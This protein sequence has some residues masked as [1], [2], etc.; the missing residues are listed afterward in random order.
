MTPGDTIAAI[1]SATGAAARMILRLSGPRAHAIAQ[2]LAP[3]WTPTPASATHTR[4]SFANLTCPA[5]LYA[6]RSP[7]SYTGEDLIEFHIPGNSMLAK[8]LL[9]ELLSPNQGARL[10]DAGE[11]TARAY[12]AG[13]LD[14][15]EAEGVAATIAASNAQE[16]SAARQLLAG[17]L[18]HRL[19][20]A[21]DQ[22][23]GTL[24]LVEVGID[25]SEEDVTFLATDE[26]HRRVTEIDT[27]L[28]A[29]LSD[30]ARFERLIHEPRIVLVGRPNAGKSTLIN[31]LSGQRRSIVSDIA[32]T[33]RD[34]LSAPLDLQHGR[35]QLL[36]V[37]GIEAHSAPG[38]I[39]RQMQKHAAR[40]IETAEHVVLVHDATDAN[41]P[42]SLIRQPDLVVRS[43]S[44]LGAHHEFQAS[45]LLVSAKTGAG[46][47]S[48]RVALD[49]LTF[50]G[51]ENAI[52]AGLALNRRH[53]GGIDEARSALSRVAAACAAT[54]AAAE[55]IA[56]ELR[57]ALDA[58]GRIL[59]SVT[60][61]DVL[62]RIFSSFCIGK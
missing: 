1:S 61:D 34:V 46:L 20:P 54:N 17:E 30:S 58:L 29:L 32:G 26:I 44:D 53:V 10:A 49:H 15:S 5:W 42:P 14:L 41:P 13:K 2:S 16:L 59:G 7:H 18:A 31:A 9:D 47:D 22:L 51:S 56:L 45:Q 12:F 55:L 62:G 38:E 24:A 11:F 35:V 19:R 23:A 48:L 25:F 8:L 43:K 52:G 60:P 39:D 21:V 37:A 40:A 3:N 27:D 36:D 28:E 50:G 33:T 6:F 57:E 4:L